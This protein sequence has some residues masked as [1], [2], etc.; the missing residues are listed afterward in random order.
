MQ[1]LLNNRYRVL[2]TWGS[3]GF[4]DTFL[5][6]DTQM[7]SLRR[8]VVKRLRPIANQQEIYQLVQEQFQ[9]EVAILEELGDRCEQIPRLYAYSIEGR[10]FY[11][12]Q[13]W[14]AGQTLSERVRSHP[15]DETTVRS[16][17]I[18]LTII[19]TPIASVAIDPPPPIKTTLARPPDQGKRDRTS[20]VGTSFADWK[21]CSLL[22]IQ[23]NGCG[24][25]RSTEP[26]CNRNSNLSNFPSAATQQLHFSCPSDTCPN[27]DAASS[28]SV[29]GCTHFN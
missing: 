12:V 23:R 7:P 29:H 17:L 16:L 3:G 6:E 21:P 25:W 10:Q 8:C 15:L 5:A 14:I 19:T 13:E 18:N 22:A 20:G 1:T 11:L 26:N 27:S 28:T 24:R 2:E 4:G 9:R